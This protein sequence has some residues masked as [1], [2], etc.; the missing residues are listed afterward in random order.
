MMLNIELMAEKGAEFRLRAAADVLPFV[1]SVA[2]DSSDVL[3]YG[4]GGSSTP[5]TWTDQWSS[6]ASACLL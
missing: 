2:A 3:P 6:N 5:S 1:E 4:V